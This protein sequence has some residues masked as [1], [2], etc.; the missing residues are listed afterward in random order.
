MQ[1]DAV[2]TAIDLRYSQE[3]EMDHLMGQVGGSGDVVVNAI[4]RFGPLR[5]HLVPDQS[6]DRAHVSSLCSERR[7]S[8]FEA[9]TSQTPQV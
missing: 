5:G 2:R 6:L 7:R 3:D 9:M 1:V 4:K 8:T